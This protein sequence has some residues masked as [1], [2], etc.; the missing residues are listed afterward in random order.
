MKQIILNLLLL[1]FPV[2]MA[3][4]QIP[5]IPKSVLSPTAASLGLYGEVPVSHFTGI[6]GKNRCSGLFRSI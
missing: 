5:E 6:S 2:G 3:Y 4:G 1:L